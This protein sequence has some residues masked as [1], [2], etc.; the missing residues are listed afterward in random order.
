MYQARM[1]GALGVTHVTLAPQR[2]RAHLVDDDE[3][4]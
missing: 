1:A 2:L 4:R 3:V